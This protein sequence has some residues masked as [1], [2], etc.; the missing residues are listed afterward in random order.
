MAR[1]LTLLGRAYCHLCDDMRAELLP[2]LAGRDV[3]LVQVDVDGDPALE[4]RYGAD[5]PVL[6]DGAPDETRI[7]SRWHLDHAKVTAALAQ[8]AKMR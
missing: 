4:T 6:F 3:A 5:V 7:L 8:D 1:T 2:L